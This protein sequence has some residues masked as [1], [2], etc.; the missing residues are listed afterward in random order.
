MPEVRLGSH[1]R[2]AVHAGQN[3][4]VDVVVMFENRNYRR[5]GA[6]N[7]SAYHDFVA[8]R[9][10]QLLWALG[11]GSLAEWLPSLSL[12]GVGGRGLYILRPADPDRPGFFERDLI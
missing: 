4:S 10:K 2:S 12:R 7:H 5:P 8:A 6:T 1:S 3:A 11:S 9:K